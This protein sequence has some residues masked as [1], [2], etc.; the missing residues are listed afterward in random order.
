MDNAFEKYI[1]S[2]FGIPA[3]TVTEIVSYFRPQSLAKGDFFL[4]EGANCDK[5]GF[6]QSG[7]M[8]EYLIDEQG[9]EV[10]KWIS[11]QGYFVVDIAGFLFQSPA[12]W[13]LQAL[14]DCELLVIQ[15][16]DYARIGQKVPQWPELEKMFIA[17]CFT[18]LEQRIVT[19]LSLSSEERYALFFAHY[20]ELFN[21]VPLQYLASMLGMTPETFS[22]IRNKLAK[23]T[24]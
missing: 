6:V 4:K 16:S 3:E 24:S 21:L 18:I 1:Q 12:R 14:S 7:I 15:K 19:H 9:R 17:R 20:R 11:T 8:R 5:M 2:Y 22:R 23:K 10:T 13:N